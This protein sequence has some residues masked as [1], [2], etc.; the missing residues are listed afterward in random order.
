MDIQDNSEPIFTTKETKDATIYFIPFEEE[1][2]MYAFDK[3]IRASMPY[4][5][6]S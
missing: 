4:L 1:D 3:E 5:F 2:K 6:K